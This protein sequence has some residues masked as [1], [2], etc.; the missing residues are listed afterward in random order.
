[1]IH[2]KAFVIDKEIAVIG[3]F[4]LDSRS[5]FLSTESMLVIHSPELVE[6]FG[7]NIFNYTD[8]SLL[9]D[10]NYNYKSNERVEE[11]PVNRLKKFI[12]NVSSKLVR[13]FDYML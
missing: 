2:S 8:E 11:L 4:N 6:S 7:E 5:A 12:F 9:V 3:S 10:K 1:S 13:F